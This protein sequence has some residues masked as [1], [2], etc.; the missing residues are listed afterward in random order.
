MFSLAIK[1]INSLFVRRARDARYIRNRRRKSKKAAMRNERKT[2]C[3]GGKSDLSEDKKKRS[4]PSVVSLDLLLK[5]AKVAQLRLPSVCVAQRIM[6]G[7]N[8]LMANSLFCAS[9]R[10][11][12]ER[13]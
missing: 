4:A 9:T 10:G 6:T 8:S 3:A 7:I 13:L 11:G 2:D 12:A 5:Y 1:L